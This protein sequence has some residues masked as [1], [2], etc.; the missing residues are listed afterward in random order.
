MSRRQD[1]HISLTA[2]SISGLRPISSRKARN[3]LRK[4]NIRPRRPAIRPILLPRH[5]AARLTWCRRYLRF[6]IHDWANILFTDESQFHLDS[7]DGRS[8]VYRCVGERY[9]S[10]N[11]NRFVGAVLWCGE[12]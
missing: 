2:R 3:R 7:N 1:N 11:V 8:R 10:F 4:H 6:R 5:R 12:A 9:V